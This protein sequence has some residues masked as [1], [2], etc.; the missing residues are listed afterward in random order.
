[1][2]YNIHLGFFRIQN[3]EIPMGV[4]IAAESSALKKFFKKFNIP[5]DDSKGEESLKGSFEKIVDIPH[6]EQ[7]IKRILVSLIEHFQGFP[8]SSD[9]AS[10]LYIILSSKI[11][12]SMHTF[13][14]VFR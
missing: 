3:M 7:T 12:Y 8:S 5:Y 14:K 4:F 13:N 2:E 1:M 10:L 6:L 9:K 11:E